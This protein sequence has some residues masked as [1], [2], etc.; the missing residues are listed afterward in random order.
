[1]RKAEELSPQDAI[2][3]STTL[4]FTLFFTLYFTRFFTLLCSLRKPRHGRRNAIQRCP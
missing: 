3:R 1:V 2:T 4:F